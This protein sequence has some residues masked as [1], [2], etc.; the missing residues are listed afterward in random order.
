MTW[1]T[2]LEKPKEEDFYLVAVETDDGEETYV[3]WFDGKHW[4]HDGEKTFQHGY[5]FRPYAWKKRPVAPDMNK[6]ERDD[7]E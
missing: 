1:K 3:L 6:F 4:I 2:V 7:D 5:Y